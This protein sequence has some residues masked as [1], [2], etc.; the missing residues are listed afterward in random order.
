MEEILYLENAFILSRLEIEL[1]E[2]N[3]V[4]FIKKTDISVLPGILT[5]EYYAILYSDISNK[6]KIIEIYENIKIDHAIEYE[7]TQ[8]N[9][10]ESFIKYCS[11]CGFKNIDSVEM[12]ENCGGLL[13]VDKKPKINNKPSIIVSILCFLLPLIGIIIASFCNNPDERKRYRNCALMGFL[14]YTTI[15]L[16]NRCIREVEYKKATN[17]FI[18]EI[19]KRNSN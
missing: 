4:Y 9:L 15:S 14:F 2:L 5:D 11:H 3:I 8:N 16:I 13:F 1:A 12:C 18:E 6:D 17:Q 19:F 10:N 7:N